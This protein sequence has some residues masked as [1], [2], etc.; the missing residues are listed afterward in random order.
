MRAT[1][2]GFRITTTQPVDRA[3]ALDPKSWSMSSYTYWYFE[4][5]GSPEIQTKQLVVTP[6]SVSDDGLSIEIAV[7]GLRPTF[8][9][10]LRAAGLKRAADGT[11]LLHDLAMYT[12]NRIPKP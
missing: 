7:D 2:S 4:P 8:V 5:Y 10:E 12:L 3:S 6:K 11:P 9:H 1:P